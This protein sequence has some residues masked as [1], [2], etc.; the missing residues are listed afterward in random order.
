M[1]VADICKNSRLHIRRSEREMGFEK[2]GH[3]K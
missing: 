2:A 3:L 1:G